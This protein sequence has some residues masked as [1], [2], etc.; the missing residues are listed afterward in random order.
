MGNN[1]LSRLLLYTIVYT[2]VPSHSSILHV[3]Y[4]SPVVK[5]N[6]VYSWVCTYCTSHQNGHLLYWI[7]LLQ[8]IRSYSD[9]SYTWTWCVC[10]RARAPVHGA[11][12]CWQE[13]PQ[14]STY[15]RE[16]YVCYSPL[17]RGVPPFEQIVHLVAQRAE[18]AGF[19]RWPLTSI[20]W[21]QFSHC[22]DQLY[23]S[24]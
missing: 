16:F 23:C 7:G 21:H 1:F 9:W 15:S 17:S 12:M 3:P 24:T 18:S 20:T 6:Q 13:D 5:S 14:T 19:C 10:H 4:F 11:E 22:E 8:A 2:C